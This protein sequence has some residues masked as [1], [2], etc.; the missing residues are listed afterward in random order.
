[1]L[2]FVIYINI[3]RTENDSANTAIRDFVS[4]II[5]LAIAA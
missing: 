2:V 4:K 3:Y 5:E 1:M